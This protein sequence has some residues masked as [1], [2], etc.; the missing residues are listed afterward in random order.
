MNN[1][2][3]IT[4]TSFVALIAVLTSC[5]TVDKASLK[6]IDEVK[7][8]NP[9]FTKI[10]EQQPKFSTATIKCSVALGDLSSKA[11]IKMINGEYI[12]I[13]LQPLLGIEVFKVMITSDS[14]YVVDKIN[15]MAA[16]ESIGGI[17]N[18]LPKG[19][20][21][22]EV[23]KILLGVPFVVGDTL[24][25]DKYPFFTWSKNDK[26]QIVMKSDIEGNSSISFKYDNEPVLQNTTLNYNNKT[27][28]E[29]EYMQHKADAL[30]VKYPTVV[31]LQADIPQIGAPISVA[32]TN[33]TTDWNKKVIKDTN[34]SKRYKRVS[35]QEIIG[36][37]IR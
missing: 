25:A 9:V 4:L 14:L 36:K 27:I 24:T 11:Q 22:K 15:S 19:S 2:F 10:V 16:Q 20:G 34:I 5:R 1:I 31:N 3:K 8:E 12:Q 28:A 33:I 32:L 21:I 30:G 26:E 18:K 7:I 13:S 37:Y 6:N 23:Q 35:L 29:C 17:M